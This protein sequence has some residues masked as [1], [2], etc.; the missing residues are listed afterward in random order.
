MASDRVHK[1]SFLQMAKTLLTFGGKTKTEERPEDPTRKHKYLR[2][3]LSLSSTCI[4]STHGVQFDPDLAESKWVDI[5]S[6][7]P[8]L[9]H[10]NS[11][12]P[13]H[14][15]QKKKIGRDADQTIVPYFVSKQSKNMKQ[16]ADKIGRRKF[17]L[18][19][20][21]GGN[22]RRQHHNPSC[23]DLVGG[24]VMESEKMNGKSSCKPNSADE[25]TVDTLDRNT[26]D[27]F[28][29]K[30]YIETDLIEIYFE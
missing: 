20:V 26:I 21:G 19:M 22:I 11:F 25:D 2:K 24:E 8:V 14:Q 29:D 7:A 27:M 28:S 16:P 12:K 9:N 4:G 5:A 10:G 1:L 30:Q 3:T 6:V 23:P 15:S 17:S 18:K 13:K